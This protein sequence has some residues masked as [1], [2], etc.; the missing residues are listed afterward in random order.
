MPLTL[1]STA[2]VDPRDAGVAGGLLNT[3][4]VLGGALGVAAA[5]V[6]ARPHGPA[7]AQVV[8][9]YNRAFA[10]L[11]G[12]LVIGAVLALVRRR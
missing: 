11:A 2:S 10:W 9:G 12:L 1:A 8:D 7:V 6:L 3:S 4:Q 5:T